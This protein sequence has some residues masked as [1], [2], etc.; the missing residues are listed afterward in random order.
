[1]ICVFQ[2]VC[3]AIESHD[4]P[5]SSELV[6][7]AAEALFSSTLPLCSRSSDGPSFFKFSRS[8]VKT[9]ADSQRCVVSSALAVVLDA[10]P[11]AVSWANSLGHCFPLL[12]PLIDDFR[13]V[14][15]WIGLSSLRKILQ[16]CTSAGIA[17]HGPLL[18]EVRFRYYCRSASRTASTLWCAAEFSSGLYVK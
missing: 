18:L 5:W 15:Q 10:I 17:A 6:A 14:F 4:L 7:P 12:L 9:L 2:V 16:S 13:P 3:C 1:M 8:V 11:A